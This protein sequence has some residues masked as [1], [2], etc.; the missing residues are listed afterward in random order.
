M[1]VLNVAVALIGRSVQ[2]NIPR[3]GETTGFKGSPHVTLVILAMSPYFAR[4]RDTSLTNWVKF[5]KK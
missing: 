1:A 2:Q 3:S 4:G 5:H